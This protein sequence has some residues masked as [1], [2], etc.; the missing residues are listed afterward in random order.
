MSLVG[1]TVFV[2]LPVVVWGGWVWDDLKYVVWNPRL[3]DADGL[4]ALWFDPG[5]RPDTFGQP[6]AEQDVHWWPLLYSTLWLERWL[7]DGFY[8]PGFHATNIAIHCVN[9]WLVWVLL[10]RFAVPGAW[11]IALVF[12]VHPGQMVSPA[13]VMGRKDLLSTLCI[14]LA[15]RVW[16]PPGRDP[17]AP[18]SWKRVAVVCGLVVAGSLFKTL[19]VVTPAALVVVHW[20]QGGRLGRTFW[21]RLGFVAVTAA[22]MAGTAWYLFTVVSDAYRHDFTLLERILIA[23]RSLWLHGFLSVVPVESVL[24]L[25]RWEVSAADPLGWLALA[26]CG[27]GLAVLCRLAP[28]SRSPLAAAAWFVVGVSPVL[29]VLDHPSLGLSFA[30]SHHRY[31]SSIASIAL[32]VGF[33]WGWLRAHGTAWMRAAGRLAAVSLVLVCALTDLRYSFA[34][35][36]PSAWYGHMAH[37]QPDRDWLQSAV[38]WALSAEGRHEEALEAA[39]RNADAA[40]SSLR[41]RRDLGLARALAG[42][43]AGA[44]EE[45][46]VVADAIETEPSLM[47]PDV[48]LRRRE[49]T[50]KLPLTPPDVFYLRVAYGRLLACAGRDTAAAHQHRLAR[51]LYPDADFDRV[52]GED[53]PHRC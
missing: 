33:A 32:V 46:R 10:R 20:W 47:L 7:W 38:V 9:V 49:H 12:A 34:F 44:M 23:A 35:A 15:V 14:L 21:M 3:L 6:L 45:Y 29:G 31:L 2:F 24:R 53:D 36:T 5:A 25:W 51:R 48:R 28:A 13:L 43:R 41:Y 18:V 11:L 22:V 19:A 1:L 39:Q 4:Y 30:F 27:G 17:S 42:D 40:P 26:G 50:R 37:Y 52:L 8:A 16:F